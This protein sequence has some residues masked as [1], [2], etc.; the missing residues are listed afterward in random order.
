MYRGDMQKTISLLTDFGQLDG[1]TGVMKGVIWSINP[2]VNIADLTH[3]IPPQ[4]ILQGALVLGQSYNYFPAGSVHIAVVDPGV[5][6]KRRPIAAQLGSHYF[7]APDNG[8]LTIPLE[9]ARAKGQQI[10][11]VELTN[12]DY[13]LPNPS[14][15][16]HGRDIF[17]PVAAHITSGVELSQLGTPI[18]DPV[19]LQIPK[20]QQTRHGW[21]AP[22]IMIDAFGNLI[23]SL[24]PDFIQG[25]QVREIR[26]GFEHISQ[27][28]TTFGDAVSGQIIAMFDSSDRLS[29]CSVN[30]NAA[31]ALDAQI[32]DLIEIV[33]N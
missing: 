11:V 3:L 21:T 7:V 29:I 1:F 5:G 24:T 13:W 19:T 10:V 25:Q 8:L 6:T 32:G 18:N 22:V 4:N 30:G 20:P 27:I 15:S 9:N 28:S 31:I 17:A 26:F 14:R 2:S 16:F 12:P 33:L 23:T